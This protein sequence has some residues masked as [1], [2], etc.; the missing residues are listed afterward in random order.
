[1]RKYI[2]IGAALAIVVLFAAAIFASGEVLSFSAP[3]DSNSVVERGPSDQAEPQD[4]DGWG[5][6]YFYFG[7]NFMCLINSDS[8]VECF[9]SDAHNV[10]SG[11]PSGTGF[12]DID[13]GD[14]YACAFHAP[15]SFTY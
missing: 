11:A 5:S 6:P 13:G 10:V 12:S 3:D 1:M 2:P 8:I 7:P 14:S 15:S 4:I 9:G